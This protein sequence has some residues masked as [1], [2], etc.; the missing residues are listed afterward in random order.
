MLCYND[1]DQALQW[2]E[3][4]C[5]CQKEAE[6]E[7]L[8]A[9]CEKDRKTQAGVHII[10]SILYC[11]SHT[12]ATLLATNSV[13]DYSQKH[14]LLSPSFSSSLMPLFPSVL[15]SGVSR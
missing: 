1:T 7:R 8:H 11:L 15:H 10:L 4:V 3:Y 12:R 5:V 13:Q 14:S 6:S 9:Y 2:S